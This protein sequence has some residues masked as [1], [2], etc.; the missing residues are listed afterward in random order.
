LN[1]GDLPPRLYRFGVDSETAGELESACEDAVRRGFPHGVS[2]VSENDRTDA[3]VA[4]RSDLELYFT[5]EKTGRRRI[6]YT[7]VLPHPVTEEDARRFNA[8]FGRTEE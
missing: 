4:S 5:I 7:I 3:C 8:A 1:A 2:A 6:H